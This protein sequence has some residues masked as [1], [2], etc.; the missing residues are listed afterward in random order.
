MVMRPVNWSSPANRSAPTVPYAPETQ[1]CLASG[2]SPCILGRAGA[3]LACLCA[4]FG[5]ALATFPTSALAYRPLTTEDAGVAEQGVAQLELSWDY[6]RWGHGD[7]EQAL[8]FVP[9]YG[10]TPRIE[11]SAE[12]PMMIH[13]LE[14]G[15]RGGGL[16][17]IS[18]VGKV[19]LVPEGA[20]RPALTFKGV[21]KTPS[22][23]ET[24]GF[25]SGD[26]DYSVVGVASKS[27]GEATLH[28]MVGYTLI[29][30]NG[31]DDIRNVGLFGVALD[32]RVTD[33]WHIVTEVG[34]NRHPDRTTTEDPMSALTGVIYTVSPHLTIDSALRV[35]LND[36]TSGWSVTTGASIAF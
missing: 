35:G 15:H 28:A 32:Y 16:G 4:S 24:R 20:R 5:I 2:A 22:G 10:L 34:G 31:N 23:D 8:L 29:G 30:D 1:S 11:V 25:G 33:A 3:L 19:L 21:V 14:E 27:I 12:I 9:I 7:Y 6:L 17:D 36:A 18:L 26:W 13:H